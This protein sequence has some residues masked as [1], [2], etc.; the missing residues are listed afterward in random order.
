MQRGIDERVE[1]TFQGGREGEAEER[2]RW[3]LVGKLVE[4]DPMVGV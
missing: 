3:R 2:R 1:E 4:Y